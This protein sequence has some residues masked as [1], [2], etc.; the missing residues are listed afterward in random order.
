MD[1]FKLVRTYGTPDIICLN[2]ANIIKRRSDCDNSM[3]LI[4]NPEPGVTGY[5]DNKEITDDESTWIMLDAKDIYVSCKTRM[6]CKICAFELVNDHPV[7]T[8][9]EVTLMVYS[10]RR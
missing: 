3:I 4:K 5:I 1:K 8:D 6:H 10:R 2:G 7:E 9:D